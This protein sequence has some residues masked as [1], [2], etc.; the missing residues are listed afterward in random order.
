MFNAQ[1]DLLSKLTARC[2]FELRKKSSIRNL[3]NASN[4]AGNAQSK[5]PHGMCCASAKRALV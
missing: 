5:M 2:I 3:L 1:N 4:F